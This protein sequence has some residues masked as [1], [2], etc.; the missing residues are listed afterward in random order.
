MSR[1]AK[2]YI[3][4]IVYI[5]P[6]ENDDADAQVYMWVRQSEYDKGLDAVLFKAVRDW[7]DSS[8]PFKVVIYPGRE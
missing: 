3:I 4:A 5:D 7:M 8:W 2:G 6:A 1:L